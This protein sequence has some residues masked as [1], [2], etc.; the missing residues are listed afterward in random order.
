MTADSLGMRIRRARDRLDWTQAQLGKAIGRSSR[1]VGDWERDVKKPRN[2]GLLEQ[3]LGVNL[4][5]PNGSGPPPPPTDPGEREVWDKLG[6]LVNDEQR[7][8]VIY[9]FREDQKRKRLAG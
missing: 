9:V 6:W 5:D 8:R 4:T 7:W 1:A 3:V 2:I